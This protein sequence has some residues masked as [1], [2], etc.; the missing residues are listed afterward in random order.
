MPCWHGTQFSFGD[1]EGLIGDYAWF[2][3]GWRDGP[4]PGGNTSGEPY[5]HAVGLKKP[6]SFGLFDVHGNAWEWVAHGRGL[7]NRGGSWSSAAQVCRSAYR[8]GGAPSS[9][10]ASL[11]FRVALS[12]PGAKPHEAAA[13]D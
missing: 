1:D 7:V 6:N 2:G 12:V 9:R 5:A 4:I 13:G 3:S 10:N 8:L 11:G